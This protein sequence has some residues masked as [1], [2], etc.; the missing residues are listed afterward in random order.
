[1]QRY[2]DRH[3]YIDCVD[4]RGVMIQLMAAHEAN[5]ALFRVIKDGADTWDGRTAP[6][7]KIDWSSGRPIAPQI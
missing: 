3:A 4:S 6:I 5:D 2:G 7:R 1:M